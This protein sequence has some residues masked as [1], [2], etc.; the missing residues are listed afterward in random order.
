ML[1]GVRLSIFYD[2]EIFL[3]IIFLFSAIVILYVK[4]IFK[5]EPSAINGIWLFE[6]KK[7]LSCRK[8]DLI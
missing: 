6:F 1:K 8:K 7:S 4:N 5:E 3:N 2:Y